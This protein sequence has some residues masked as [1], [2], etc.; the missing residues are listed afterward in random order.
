MK[1]TAENVR[2]IGTFLS[3]YHSDLTYISKFH[4]YKNGKIKTADFIQK[5]KGS[6]KSFINDFRVARN[7]DKDETEK[8]L[9]LTTS[10]VKTESNALRID[11]F[12]EHLKQSGISRDKTP[13]SLAS[14]ILF[15]NNPINIL[16][17]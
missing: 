14:K 8:L 6:F 3:S 4:D 2:A 1:L 16:P 12:A 5:G 17:N 15:L 10:W 13:H 9:G 11:E 7:I